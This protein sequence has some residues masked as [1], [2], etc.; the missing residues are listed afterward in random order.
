MGKQAEVVNEEASLWTVE[1]TAK[2][3]GVSHSWVY[4]R[5]EAG[6]LPHLRIGPLLRF[7]PDT[8]RKFVRRNRVSETNVIARLSAR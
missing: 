4:R 8:L 3:L 2:F 5:A 1:Q 6:L 7:E